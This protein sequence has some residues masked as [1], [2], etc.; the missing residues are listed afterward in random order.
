MSNYT[1]LVVDY[2][3]RSLEVSRA[4]LAAAGFKVETASDGVAG[5][6]AYNRLKPDLVLIEAMLP[7]KHGFEVCQTIKSSPA[8][9]RTP[10]LITTAVYKGRKYR[11]QALHIY[12][13]DDYVEKPIAPEALVELCRRFLK[14][15]TPAAATAMP[16]AATLPAAGTAAMAAAASQQKMNSPA[17]SFVSSAVARSS[18]GPRASAAA[19]IVSDL[20]EQE[21]MARLDAILPDDGLRRTPWTDGSAAPELHPEPMAVAPLPEVA[22]FA[23]RVPEAVFA[24]MAAP[25]SDFGPIP[26]LDS[27]LAGLL[28]EPPATPE[29]PF[30]VAPAVHEATSPQTESESNPQV[31]SFD[32]AR[33]RK[34]PGSRGPA[35]SAAEATE[36]QAISMADM[37]QAHPEAR[38]TEVPAAVAQPEVRERPAA[39]VAAAA[40]EEPLPVPEVSTRKAGVPLWVWGAV[41]CIVAVGALYLFFGSSGSQTTPEAPAVARQATVAEPPRTSAAENRPAPKSTVPAVPSNEKPP[42]TAATRGGARNAEPVVQ[43]QAPPKPAPGNATAQASAPKPVPERIEKTPPV[44]ATKSV[45]VATQPTA[46]A[47][48]VRAQPRNES[49]APATPPAVVQQAQPAATE[50]VPAAAKPVPQA[51]AEAAPAAQTAPVEIA[52]AAAPKTTVARGALMDLG[53]VDVQPVS[54]K[55]ALPAYTARARTLG[56]RGLVFLNILVD[57]NGRVTDVQV[58]QGIPDSDLNDAAAQAARGWVYQPATKDGVPVKVW[59]FEKISFEP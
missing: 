50:P 57:E 14:D 59:K 26:E 32:P 22:P 44:L 10:V 4:P 20:T 30:T 31:V 49:P 29:R 8:G 56:Q 37:L 23:P 12:G 40:A 21:I 54:V 35:P 6:E 33:K 7:K 58:I 55:R 51:P 53:A 34:R 47:P 2:E 43:P 19:A 48:A 1:I 42:L 18:T 27:V 41:A 39:K 13:C 45:P 38:K 36:T 16:V 9:K 5:L 24:P 11:T 25:E 52:P 46:A 17:A 3:P 28:P 15:S